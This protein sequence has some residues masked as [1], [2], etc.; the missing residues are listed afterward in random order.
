MSYGSEVS[1]TNATAV[2]RVTVEA[3]IAEAMPAHA[4]VI[5]SAFA[6]PR[7]AGVSPAALALQTARAALEA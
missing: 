4:A 1:S 7:A 2:P 3:P 5:R 6:A